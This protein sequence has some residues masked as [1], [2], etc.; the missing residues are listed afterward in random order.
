MSHVI[1]TLLGLLKVLRELRGKGEEF[2]IRNPDI[3]IPPDFKQFFSNGNNK[4][5]LM[6]LIED[7]WKDKT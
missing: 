3:R 6:E 5:R 4:E 2:V 7:V 1:P